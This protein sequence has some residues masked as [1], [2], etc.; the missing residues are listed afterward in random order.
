MCELLVRQTSNSS[1]DPQKEP[2]TWKLGMTISIQPDGWAWSES[3]RGPA[4]GIIKMP[5]VEADYMG[6]WLHDRVED[7]QVPEE[8][9]V[10]VGRRSHVIRDGMPPP[11]I[12]TA[13][14]STS[15]TPAMRRG[16]LMMATDYFV[17]R[18]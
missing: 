8:E 11:G 17:G 18:D 6:D 2:Y 10:P 3:E 15:N 9:Q 4:Y 14:E 5:E 16:L 13:L 7:D 1:A 12:L